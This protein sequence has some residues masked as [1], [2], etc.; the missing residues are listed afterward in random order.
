MSWGDLA[1]NA[2]GTALPASGACG[3]VERVVPR[4]PALPFARPVPYA[5]AAPPIHPDG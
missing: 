5:A 3:N 1:K 2:A 4:H